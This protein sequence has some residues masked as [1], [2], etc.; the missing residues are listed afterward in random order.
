MFRS[1]ILARELRG[2]LVVLLT[3]ALIFWLFSRLVDDRLEAQ[4]ASAALVTTTTSPPRTTTTTLVVVDDTERLCSLSAAFREDLRSI[5]VELVNQAGDPL[6]NP[7]D[8]VIDIGPVSY[9][10]LTL[11][12]NREV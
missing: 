8:R 9:T 11:P 7:G 10:H 5:R 4:A 6:S 1:H 2:A 3:I 12:T